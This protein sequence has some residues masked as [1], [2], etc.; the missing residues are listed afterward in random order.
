MG[1]THI[2]LMPVSEHPFDGLMGLS[3]DR[4]FA[5]T[6]R[7]GGPEDFCGADRDLPRQ[8]IRRRLDWVPGHFPDDPHGSAGSTDRAYEHAKSSTG[9]HLEWGR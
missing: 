3:A 2:E 5:P 7:F 4:R 6:S 9:R 8:G 1:F